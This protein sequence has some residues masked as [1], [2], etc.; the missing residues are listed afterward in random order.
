MDIA[1]SDALKVII[2][3]QS[4]KLMLSSGILST[5]EQLHETVKETFGVTEEFSLQY[6]NEDFGE[7][8]T[9]HS[10][11]Q[12][13]HKGTIKVVIIPS[14]V[15]TLTSSTENLIAVSNLN[16]SSSSAADTSAGNQAD[17]SSVS[18]Q[19]TI[20]LSPF[21]SP[22]RTVCPDKVLIPLFSAATEALLRN[23]K[24]EYVKDCTVL[25]NT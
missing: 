3:H 13:R 12:I 19:D 4:E 8:F 14:V 23:A 22:H 1:W 5:V 20:M 16:D 11:N 21:G 9:L 18:S 10:T 17:G 7:Y 2:E 15:L 24:K 6:L 25:I